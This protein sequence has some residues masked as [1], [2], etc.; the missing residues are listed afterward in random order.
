VRYLSMMASLAAGFAGALG[1]SPIRLPAES[2]RAACLERS[3]AQAC[4]RLGEELERGDVAATLPEEPGLYLALACAGGR[5]GACERVQPWAQRYTDY[6]L[7]ELDVGCVLRNNAFACEELADE[8]REEEEVRISDGDQQLLRLGRARMRRA[9]ELHRS[10]CDR[11]DA[12]AC[13]GASRVYRSGVGV[14]F[15]PRAARA[16]AARACALGLTDGCEVAK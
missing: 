11:G 14:P 6:E 3:Q 12:S 15:D 9:L 13:L 2:L 7:L 8:L 5:T 16:S 10:G 4:E 1:G